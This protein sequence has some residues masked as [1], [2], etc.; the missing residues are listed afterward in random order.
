ML[1]ENI[2][3]H[4][5]KLTNEIKKSVSLTYH[6]RNNLNGYNYIISIE[7]YL[8]SLFLVNNKLKLFIHFFNQLC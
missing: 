7:P 6:K 5:N 3:I 2:W 8:S 1:L 4:V